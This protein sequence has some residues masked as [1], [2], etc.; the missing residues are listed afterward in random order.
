M[1]IWMENEIETSQ[2]CLDCLKDTRICVEPG[3]Y[4]MLHDTLW[5]AITTPRERGAMLCVPC[6]SKRLGR[7]LT[8]A[9]FLTSPVEMVTRL[10]GFRLARMT[11]EQKRRVVETYEE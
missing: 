5:Q 1:T 7:P 4:Y 11:D 3:N 10:L 8:D 6:A 2:L 9:D